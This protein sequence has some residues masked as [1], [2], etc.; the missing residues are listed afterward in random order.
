MV[1]G[2]TIDY[3][4]PSLSEI[5]PFLR[6][7]NPSVTAS[8]KFSGRP[9]WSSPWAVLLMSVACLTTSLVAAQ[10]SFGEDPPA[11]KLSLA[12]GKLELA[13]PATW[14]VVPPKSSIVQYEFKAP[15]LA[16]EDAARITIM[17]ASGGVEANIDR[18]IGQFDG[19]TKNDAKIDKKQ[20]AGTTIHVVK[21][22]ETLFRV[23]RLY[24]VPVD[25]L[26]KWNKLPDDIIEVGQK[27]IVG[28]E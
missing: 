13:A 1:E 7:R 15:K 12:G 28:M 8:A 26:K 25:K 18:W 21:P 17:Q 2:S 4:F 27:L 9:A 5:H 23:S 16:G 20:V 22:G 6:W 3:T 14:E 24:G 10:T 19:A 11:A